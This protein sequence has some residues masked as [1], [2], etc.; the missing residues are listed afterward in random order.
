[1]NIW[2][3]DFGLHY[4]FYRLGVE[5]SD[6]DV[7]GDDLLMFSTK[8]RLKMLFLEYAVVVIGERIVLGLSRCTRTSAGAGSCR[9]DGHGENRQTIFLSETKRS[10]DAIEG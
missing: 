7:L 1:M 2:F 3:A 4:R 6:R 8:T 10:R 9:G 5:D